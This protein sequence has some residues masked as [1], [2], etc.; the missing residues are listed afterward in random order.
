[1]NSPRKK[2]ASAFFLHALFFGLDKKISLLVP[3]P[4]DPPKNCTLTNQT[5]DSLQVDCREGF[6]S[7]LKQ[8]FHMEVFTLPEH[9]LVVNITARSPKLLAR[10]LPPDSTLFLRVYASTA[11]GRSRSVTFE[12]YTLH[13]A[14]KQTGKKAGTTTA[15]SRWSFSGQ[16]LLVK[17]SR[18]N[19]QITE[20]LFS[21]GISFWRTVFCQMCFFGVDL[22]I[23]MLG[24]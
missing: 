10:G 8:E 5:Q 22:C 15:L 6:S 12:G 4:P 1:M 23:R 11:K 20:R 24:I 19:L 7:G 3:G 21:F 17:S 13:M 16:C 9:Q 18:P 2:I 14:D